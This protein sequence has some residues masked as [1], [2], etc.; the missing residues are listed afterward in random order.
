MG[1]A[2]SLVGMGIDS[3]EPSTESFTKP[4]STYQP[5]VLVID[6]DPIYGR[7]IKK[8]AE[9]RGLPLT[10][11]EPVLEVETL[12]FDHGFDVIVLDYELGLYKGTQLAPLFCE[13][14]VL[15]VSSTNNIERVKKEIGPITPFLAKE[16]GPNELLKVIAHL[17][18]MGWAI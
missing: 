16:E 7:Y 17:G 15:I 9:K 3:L 14:P 4:A 11:I 1:T 13:A 8:F 18:G 2:I 6:D 10:F 5:H 12:P